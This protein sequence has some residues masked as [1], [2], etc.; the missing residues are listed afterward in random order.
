MQRPPEYLKDYTKQVHFLYR[1]L[2]KTMITK[3][4]PAF[5]AVQPSLADIGQNRI[6]IPEKN[7][8]VFVRRGGFSR[9][10]SWL[11][12]PLFSKC[13]LTEFILHQL[14]M[15]LSMSVF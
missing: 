12:T 11:S 14:L 7:T 2:P 1:A 13:K 10:V 3:P 4:N 9:Q 5:P 6:I 15:A 8:E